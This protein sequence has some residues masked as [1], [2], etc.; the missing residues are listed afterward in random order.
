MD[1]PRFTTGQVG[2][3]TYAHLNEAFQLLDKLRPLLISG[4]SFNAGGEALLVARI[5]GTAAATPSLM[6]WEEVVLKEAVAVTSVMQ[7]QARDGG[8]TSAAATSAEFTPAFVPP[9]FGQSSS[10]ALPT[11][12]VA[13]LRRTT[14]IDGK[15]AWMVVSSVSGGSDIFPARIDS[16]RTREAVGGVTFR[17]LYSWTEV[18]LLDTASAGFYLDWTPVTNGRVGCQAATCS[19]EAFNGAERY[20]THGLGGTGPAGANETNASIGI[21]TVVPLCRDA[22]SGLYYFSLGPATNISCNIIP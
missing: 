16:A 10:T 7:W 12:T 18:A 17:W 4:S 5:T 6:T 2:N 3:L 13:L 22:V 15:P 19:A 1:L 21:G 20:S 11:G 14:R 8:R 9:L